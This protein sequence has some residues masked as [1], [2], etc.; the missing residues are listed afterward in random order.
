MTPLASPGLP[1]PP[2]P[3]MGSPCPVMPASYSSPGSPVLLASPWCRAGMVSEGEVTCPRLLLVKVSTRV[4]APQGEPRALCQ[5][6]DSQHLACQ[7][8][9]ESDPVSSVD[10]LSLFLSCAGCQ[11]GAYAPGIN[12]PQKSRQP[13]ASQLKARHRGHCRGLAKPLGRGRL[14]G[15]SIGPFSPV[16]ALT[17]LGG[18][19]PSVL[20]LLPSVTGGI[21]V[22]T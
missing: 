17:A 6:P 13:W 1:S 4:Q 16:L 12:Q 10:T 19:A 7:V 3:G 15:V 5:L 11:P 18:S 2:L 20:T 21:L 8:A 14:A 22:P 9:K